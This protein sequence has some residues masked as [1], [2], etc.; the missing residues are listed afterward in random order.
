MNPWWLAVKPGSLFKI[1]L[2]LAVGLSMGFAAVSTIDYQLIAIALVLAFCV[3]WAIVLLNDYADRDADI[4][5]KARFPELID[6]RVLV[7][8]LLTPEQV[9]AVGLLAAAG[10]VASGAVLVFSCDRPDAV[11]LAFLGL[12][13][14]WAYSFTPLRL[15]YRGGGEL[16]ETLGVGVVLPVTGYY[17]AAGVLPLANAHLFLPIAFYAFIGALASGLKHEPADR[18]NGKRTACV[19]FGAA[20]VRKFIW[21]AQMAARVWFGTFFLIGEYGHSALV[22]GALAPSAPM[23]ITR[24]FDADADFRNASALSR[25]KRSL[26]QASYLTS[27]ALF[28]DFAFSNV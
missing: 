13:V 24:R 28:L 6:T 22:L 3:Q 21:V 9:F 4:A 11:Y 7:E 1:L 15:N 2:P 16:C 12:V 26:V 20:R 25:Y 23:F 17:I 18:E 10:T 19:L 27:L 8:G 5:H 14:F